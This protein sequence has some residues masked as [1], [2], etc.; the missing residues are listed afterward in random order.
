M[1]QTQ[2]ASATAVN[3]ATRD[4]VVISSLAG[5]CVGLL[6]GARK[7]R[8]APTDR[9]THQLRR[10]MARNRNQAFESILRV[11]F[12]DLDDGEAIAD[13]TAAFYHAAHALEAHAG[14]RA[15]QVSL[16]NSLKLSAQLR[17]SEM[18]LTVDVLGGDQSSRT[19][20]LL[21]QTLARESALIEEERE[22]VRE[23][24]YRPK[25]VA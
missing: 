19:L 1:P 18:E 25:A 24:M 6:L 20:H 2:R 11:G 13:I 10:D 14:A 21:D 17:A 7:Q 15:L 5:E 8:P 9:A 3:H 23:K 22:A 16:E 4:R 12:E